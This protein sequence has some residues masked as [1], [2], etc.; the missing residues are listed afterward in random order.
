[1]IQKSGR[2]RSANYHVV[3]GISLND[4][5]IDPDARSSRRRLTVGAAP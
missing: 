3:H 5:P 1:M 2:V 4:Y